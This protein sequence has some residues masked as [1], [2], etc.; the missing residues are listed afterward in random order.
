MPMLANSRHELFAQAVA[1]GRSASQAYRQSGANGKNADVQAAKLVAGT[2]LTDSRDELRRT[3]HDDSGIDRHLFP[4]QSLYQ[5]DGCSLLGSLPMRPELFDLFSVG[6]GVGFRNDLL[7]NLPC[8]SRYRLVGGESNNV[9][10]ACHSPSGLILRF[11][12]APAFQ[13]NLVCESTR[14]GPV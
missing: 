11:H 9:S 3:G 1:S 12:I 6:V 2:L 4:G 13:G 14:A 5:T 8:S 7:Q 10:S